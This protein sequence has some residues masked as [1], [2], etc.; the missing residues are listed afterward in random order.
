MRAFFWIALVP[1]VACGESNERPFVTGPSDHGGSSDEQPY[2][3]DPD[4]I[5]C[6]GGYRSP[7]AE[8][9]YCAWSDGCGTVGNCFSRDSCDSDAEEICGCDGNTY[10]DE[11]EAAQLG[12]SLSHVGACAAKK[13]QFACGDFTCDDSSYCLDLVDQF[14]AGQQRYFCL[15]VPSA[16]SSDSCTCNV[17]LG[18]ACYTG[19]TCKVEGN[20]LVVRCD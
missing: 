18:K 13:Q 1:A 3:P 20:H 8:A 7:C 6:G 14:K 16:C 19:S 11:C 4:P 2:V 10:A 17:D 12:V 15:P 5:L 9:K